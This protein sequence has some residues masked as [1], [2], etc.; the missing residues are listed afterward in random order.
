M[1]KRLGPGTAVAKQRCPGPGW[2]PLVRSTVSSP[3]FPHPAPSRLPL[4]VTARDSRKATDKERKLLEKTAAAKADALRDDDNVF[5]VSF[6]QQGWDGEGGSTL[7]ATD[8]KVHNLSI[9]A[10]G[11]VGAD[12]AGVGARRGWGK[13]G[14]VDAGVQRRAGAAARLVVLLPGWPAPPPPQQPLVE[15]AASTIAAK[16]DPAALRLPPQPWPPVRPAPLTPCSCCW[17]VER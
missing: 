15:S 10:K 6:E 3:H 14:V 8:I 7:S 1:V 11:K 4:Q 17:G 13:T 12:Q 16:F 2:W 5:D 9:R